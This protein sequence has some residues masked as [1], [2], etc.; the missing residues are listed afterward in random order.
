MTGGGVGVVYTPVRGKDE[1]IR[2]MGGKSTGPVSLMQMNNECGRHIIQG[3]SRRS[4]LWAGLHWW[5]PD[6]EYFITI[7]DWPEWLKE[8]KKIDFNTPAP[9]DGTNISV[10]LDSDFFNAIYDPFWSKTYKLGNT[11]FTLTHKDAQ[12]RYWLSVEHM[13]RTGEPG[14]SVDNGINEGENL[15]NACTEVTSSTNG[16]M[17][18]LLSLN[19]ARIYTKEEFNT[20]TELG[21]IFLLCGT[22]YSKLPLPEMYK[23]RE[24]TRRLGLGLM[25]VHEWLLRRERR[26]GPDDELGEWLDL[27]SKSGDFANIYA[28]KLGISRPVAT[29]SIAPTGTISIA[30]ET[31]GGIEPIFASA[32]LR[33]YLKDGTKWHAQ[34]VLDATAKRLVDDGVDPDLIE[35]SYTLS[36]DIDRRI[37]FQTWV[38]QHVDHGI[39]STLNLPA[40]GSSINNENTVKTFATKLLK[41]LPNLRGITVYPDGARGGQPLTRL[42]YSEAIRR[43]VG[44]EFMEQDESNIP[45]GA[46]CKGGLCGE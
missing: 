8:R 31:T 20:L 21:I 1:H 26:Y 37:L 28:D 27:Y 13:L 14:F 44:I 42:G 24:T 16:D 5:D 4:A 39:S 34:Y 23:V 36:E 15:R 43:G 41:Y 9:M 25:G 10:I 22:L 32:Y 38:Q 30:A 35:D 19:M 11:S 45:E 12:K 3:G 40:W 33:R 17:C 46:F 7:K 29:R 6:C 18:N 2:G